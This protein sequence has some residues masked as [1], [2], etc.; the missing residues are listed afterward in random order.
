[1]PRKR[2]RKPKTDFEYDLMANADVIEHLYDLAGSPRWMRRHAGPGGLYDELQ[3]IVQRLRQQV[4]EVQAAQLRHIPLDKPPAVR[5]G[6][7]STSRP[8]VSP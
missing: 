1:M 6:D 2:S 5:T 7:A 3:R 8:A 4:G